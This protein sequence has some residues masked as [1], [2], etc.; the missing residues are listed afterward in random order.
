MRAVDSI[1]GYSGV[2][3]LFGTKGMIWDHSIWAGEGPEPRK[4]CGGLGLVASGGSESIPGRS[5]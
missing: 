4:G 1:P 3:V 5:G 2:Y